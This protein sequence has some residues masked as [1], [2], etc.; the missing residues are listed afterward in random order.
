M[1]SE[2]LNTRLFEN[3]RRGV[4]QSLNSSDCVEPVKDV[5]AHSYLSD[6]EG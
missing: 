5:V 6:L 1:R 3:S 4:P 2:Q